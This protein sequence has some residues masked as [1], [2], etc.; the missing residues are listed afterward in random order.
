MGRAAAQFAQRPHSM[1]SH[2]CIMPC[3][4]CTARTCAHVHVPH[5]DADQCRQVFIPVPLFNIKTRRWKVFW[6]VMCWVQLGAL[7]PDLPDEDFNKWVR[8]LQDPD[9]NRAPEVTS[10]DFAC[11]I[12]PLQPQSCTWNSNAAAAVGIS[13]EGLFKGA[14]SWGTRHGP[15]EPLQH[16]PC[17]MQKPWEYMPKPKFFR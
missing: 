6:I 16:M 1:L 14:M 4:S 3:G 8:H 12:L 13:L 7:V 11:H 2:I 15:R 10:V 5:A 9:N 17:P